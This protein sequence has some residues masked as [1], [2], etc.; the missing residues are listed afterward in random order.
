MPVTLDDV[1]YCMSGFRGYALYAISLDAKG[2]VTD[3]DAVRWKRTDSAPYVASPLIYDGLLY[4]TKDR[5]GIISCVDART[6][7]PHFDKQPCS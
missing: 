2:D 7:K 5:S 4:F 6:G 1:V 3:G